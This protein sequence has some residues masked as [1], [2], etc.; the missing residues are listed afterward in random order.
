MPTETKEGASLAVSVVKWAVLVV[1]VLTVA[2]VACNALA[3]QA[4]DG[5]GETIEDE[6][7]QPRPL[8]EEVYDD[9]ELGA[10]KEELLA[11]LEPV[12]PVD[13]AVLER[14]QQRSPETVASSC[15]Y[16]ERLGAQRGELYRL[17]FD[18]DVLVDK[19]IVFPEAV[20]DP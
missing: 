11:R 9:I 7:S 19:T 10:Q 1:L 13:G 4:S 6:V 18:G 20:D 12:Q 17:C 15:V 2:G 3:D 16:Y 14:F 8:D 5:G